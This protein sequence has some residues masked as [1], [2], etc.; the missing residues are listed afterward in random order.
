MDEGVEGK[1]GPG[2]SFQYV[3]HKFFKRSRE[4]LKQLAQDLS[5]SWHSARSAASKRGAETKK[6]TRVFC[7]PGKHTA[8]ATRGHRR[9]AR[10]SRTSLSLLHLMLRTRLVAEASVKLVDGICLMLAD[11]RV[12]YSQSIS[13]SEYNR[14]FCV[15]NTR[16]GLFFLF[17]GKT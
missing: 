17:V 16:C 11:R 8:A 2:N 15:C 4:G 14:H 9:G 6:V 10:G 7:L 5:H 13:V 12:E 1:I 3:V